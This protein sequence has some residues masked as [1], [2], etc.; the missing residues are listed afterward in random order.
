[1]LV[2]VSGRHSILKLAQSDTLRLPWVEL[3][4]EKD[5]ELC[6]VRKFSV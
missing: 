2:S 1:M 3:E 5:E 6:P 4:L